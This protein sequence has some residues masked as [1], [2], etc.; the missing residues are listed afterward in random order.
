VRVPRHVGHGFTADSLGEGMEEKLE[1]TLW[2]A[3]RA[4]EEG[5]A[6]R[7]RMRER[8]KAQHLRPS[9]PV[10]MTRL[11]SCSGVQRHCVSCCSI[12]TGRRCLRRSPHANG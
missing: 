8:A 12:R 4:I 10:W 1:E 11:L 3:L 7:S 2:S 9:S 5:I 6:L